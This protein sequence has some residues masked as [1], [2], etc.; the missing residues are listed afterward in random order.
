MIL[1]NLKKAYR[2][3]RYGTTKKRDFRFLK[4]RL[5]RGWDD[6][7]TFSLDYSLAKLIAPRLK[8]F[9]EITVG[10]YNTADPERQQWYDEL[11]KMIAAFEFAGSEERWMA[12]PEEFKKHQEGLK[13]FA[14]HY[15]GLWW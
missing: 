8:R 10:D 7:D 13:L 3:V 5:T 4:Q 9:K 11:D 6:G 12:K 15:F 2:W 1:K 14:E